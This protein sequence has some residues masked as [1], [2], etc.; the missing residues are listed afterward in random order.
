MGCVT[1]MYVIH[2][3]YIYIYIHTYIHIY[4]YIYIYICL[5]WDLY[6]LCV[7]L[8]L[9]NPHIN[10]LWNYLYILSSVMLLHPVSSDIIW[11]HHPLEVV[12]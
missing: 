10:V 5:Y 2:I 7:D 4:I 8:R 6:I 1:T 11:Y 3:Y 9:F 12:A